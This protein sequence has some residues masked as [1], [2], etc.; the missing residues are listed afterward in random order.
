MSTGLPNT[1]KRAEATIQFFEERGR[2]VVGVTIKGTEFKLDFA[3]PEKAQ[4]HEVD[5]VDMSQ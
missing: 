4:G 5:L 3:K 1:A 2:E